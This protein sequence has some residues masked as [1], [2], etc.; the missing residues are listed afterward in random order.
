MLGTLKT[1]FNK[2][3]KTKN[4]EPEIYDPEP[5]SNPNFLI[6]T[7][8]INKL[9]KDIEEESPLCTI[10]IDGIPEEFSSSILDVQLESQQ[11]ILDELIPKHGNELLININNLKLTTIFN[12]I[13][14]AFKLNNI[15]TGSSQGI[16]YYKAAIPQRIYYPQRRTSPRIQL[17]NL[18]IPFSG[19][20]D[21]TNSTVGGQIFDLS[22]GGIGI[23]MPNNRARFQRGDLIKNCRISLED[24]PMNFDL[25]VRFVKTVNHGAGQTQ[26]GGYFENIAPKSQNKL[27]RFVA[28]LEREEIRKHKA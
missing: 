24:S 28:S 27:Q 20:S 19:V 5:S 23:T 2:K 3:E 18:N 26:V 15:K 6:D 13:H 11:I 10:S 7:R 4:P 9:L 14:L 21:R 22:R 8:K 17:N 16:A 25:T 12:G 1:L